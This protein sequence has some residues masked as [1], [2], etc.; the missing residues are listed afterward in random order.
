MKKNSEYIIKNILR[1]SLEAE[2]S[3][4]PSDEQLRR[5]HTFS[6]EFEEKMKPVL[7]SQKGS[8]GGKTIAAG[9]SLKKN[10]SGGNSRRFFYA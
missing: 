4:V 6:R 9:R 10:K 7:E 8:A 5:Q 2:L 1:E 3:A